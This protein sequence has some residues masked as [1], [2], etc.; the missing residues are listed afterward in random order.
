[1]SKVWRPPTVTAPAGTPAGERSGGGG[2]ACGTLVGAMLG[3][4]TSCYLFSYSG[5]RSASVRY[6]ADIIHSMLLL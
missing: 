4:M 3:L 6:L 1:M 5:H 2:A